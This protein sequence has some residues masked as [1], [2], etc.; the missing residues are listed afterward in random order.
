[1]AATDTLDNYIIGVGL[2]YKLLSLYPS[3]QIYIRGIGA[4]A[5]GSS[6]RI[7]TSPN[8]LSVL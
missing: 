1:M 6:A 3:Q 4:P 5:G 7:S 8:T 2:L